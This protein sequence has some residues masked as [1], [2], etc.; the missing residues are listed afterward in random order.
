[1]ASGS[2]WLQAPMERRLATVARVSFA[3]GVLLLGLGTLV[4]LG[5][6]FETDLAGQHISL[7]GFRFIRGVGACWMVSLAAV[8]LENRLWLRFST[9]WEE[10]AGTWAPALLLVVTAYGVFWKVQQYRAFDVGAYD[11]SMY[12]HALW[13]TLH[14]R[15]FHA[16]GIERNFFS[17]HASPILFVLLPFYAAFSSP[18]VLLVAQG[19]SLGFAAFATYRLCRASDVPHLAAAA[20]ASMWVLA[21]PLWRG[22][23]F[24]F[25]PEVF[26][27]GLALMAATAARRERWVSYWVWLL[28][29]LS[30]KE[31][32]ALTGLALGTF[33]FFWNRKAWRHGAWTCAV[34]IAW[35][36]VALKVVIPIAGA[37][38]GTS[39]VFLATRYGHLGHSYTEIA[40]KLLTSPGLLW[41]ALTGP[42]VRELAAS[43]AYLPLASPLSVVLSLPQLLVHRVTDYDVQ[44]DLRLYYGIGAATVWAL[45][46]PSAMQNVAR[47]SRW[48]FAIAPFL[49]GWMWLPGIQ[50]PL[51]VTEE[52]VRMHAKI[53]TLDNTERVALQTT[54][55]T[56]LTPSPTLMLFPDR[57]TATRLVL[58]P[59]K[60]KWPLD[61]EGW[62]RDVTHILE[63]EDFGV[64]SLTDG[65]LILRRGAPRDRNAATQ[66]ALWPTVR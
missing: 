42:P 15:F 2:S 23:V 50:A 31:D 30:V 27:P 4:V 37:P 64:E 36:V 46:L 40:L 51:R 35:A 52:D 44:R 33:V 47:W 61:D 5:G 12:E 66:A 41:D 57:E 14:G 55:I 13:N 20:A 54:A 32:T 24:D 45:G 1:M 9:F 21:P 43:T 38:T 58:L 63:S 65:V 25:H 11:F 34:S 62:K 48:P 10:R 18:Y 16:F 19:L 22:L 28:L 6:G 7:Y 17:E 39:N 8:A 49:V 53:S 3:L 56:H 26:G 60:F 59:G 29:C